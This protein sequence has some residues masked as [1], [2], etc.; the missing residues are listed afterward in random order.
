M[1]QLL[2]YKPLNPFFI[3]SLKVRFFF[4]SP[5][6]TYDIL[7]KVGQRKIFSSISVILIIQIPQT[8]K[9]KLMYKM[10]IKILIVAFI[11]FVLM[12]IRVHHVQVRA[13]VI[14]KISSHH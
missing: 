8:R 11:A 7:E 13:V 6:I 1:V 12:K 3:S 14:I 2:L 10:A 9:N 5:E 4:L